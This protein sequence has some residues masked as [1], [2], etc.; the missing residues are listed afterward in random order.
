MQVDTTMPIN[1]APESTADGQ[2]KIGFRKWV[3]LLV[4]S[5]ALTVIIL[6]FLVSFKL[7]D[8]QEEEAKQ[9]TA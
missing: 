1:A 6:A 2:P 8:G 3:P 4:L 9:K 7:P 5:L